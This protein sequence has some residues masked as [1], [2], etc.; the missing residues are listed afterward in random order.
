[1]TGENAL[2][3]SMARFNRYLFLPRGLVVRRQ[4]EYHKLQKDEGELRF[5]FL[6]FDFVPP[7]SPFADVARLP[8]ALRP[9]AMENDIKM[10]TRKQFLHQKWP[11]SDENPWCA[12][13]RMIPEPQYFYHDE[14]EIGDTQLVKRYGKSEGFLVKAA[15]PSTAAR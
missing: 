4:F 13:P 10:T 7:G 11:M 12:W 1:M 3:L 6:R 5:V 14:P 9:G 15:H 2:N 8:E